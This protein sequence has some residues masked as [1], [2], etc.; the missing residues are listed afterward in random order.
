[1]PL[2]IKGTT[3]ASECKCFGILIITLLLNILK[4]IQSMQIDFQ[5]QSKKYFTF[6]MNRLNE[7]KLENFP[8]IEAYI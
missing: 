1:M 5:K 2:I 4:C 6:S 8:E 3:Q 7:A